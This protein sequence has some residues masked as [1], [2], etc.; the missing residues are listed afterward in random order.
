MQQQ[1]QQQLQLEPNSERNTLKSLKRRD[2]MKRANKSYFPDNG[3]EV[4]IIDDTGNFGGDYQQRQQSHLSRKFNDREP[5]NQGE[6]GFPGTL[7]R[8]TEPVKFSEKKNKQNWRQSQILEGSG[9]LFDSEEINM[10]AAAATSSLPKVKMR[11]KSANQRRKEQQ[12]Q[13]QHWRKSEY[14][15]PGSQTLLSNRDQKWNNR[16]FTMA[17]DAEDAAAVLD[18]SEVNFQ[19]TVNLRESG[20]DYRSAQLFNRNRSKST[21]F[22][23][24]Y[25]GDHHADSHFSQTLGHHPR[26]HFLSASAHRLR[27]LDP[28]KSDVK[29]NRGGGVGG[30]DDDDDDDDED[31][32]EVWPSANNS[33]DHDKAGLSMSSASRPSSSSSP[34]DSAGLLSGKAAGI[35][36]SH[37]QHRNRHANSGSNSSSNNNSNMASMSSSELSSSS[38]GHE[39][40]INGGLKQMN[41]KQMMAKMILAKNHHTSVDSNNN[42]SSSGSRKKRSGS[43]NANK[44]KDCSGRDDEFEN[45]R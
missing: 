4:D 11:S 29:I 3:D 35:G 45:Y 20:L 21:Q 28:G 9:G 39:L 24:S 42:N 6:S 2:K 32:D 19:S 25:G 14:L 44:S 26:N 15:D 12:Q 27:F 43:K 22:L 34:R 30:S 41:K 33:S 16:R 5:F 37:H 7:K 36:N 13:Q 23:N 18:F 31:D 38:T 17:V 40:M 8:Y 10:S 1:K